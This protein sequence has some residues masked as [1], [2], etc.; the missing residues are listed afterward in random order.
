MEQVKAEQNETRI[1]V[2]A[3]VV[4][5]N[6]WDNI[7][8]TDATTDTQ[9]PQV[10]WVA[11]R[12]C[13]TN[14]VSYVLQ[15]VRRRAP[16]RMLLLL[17]QQYSYLQQAMQR[18]FGVPGIYMTYHSTH[19]ICTPEYIP[20]RPILSTLNLVDCVRILIILITVWRPEQ[21]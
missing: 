3:I 4:Y 18:D 10:R 2:H 11:I 9:I 5:V 7:Q 17:H 14:S 13:Y 6:T 20:A 1:Y 16:M 12:I 15:S 21:C 8:D 19:R